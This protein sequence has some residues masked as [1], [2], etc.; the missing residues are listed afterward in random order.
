MA[1]KHTKGWST[2]LIS[3]QM[4]IKS[5][6]RYYRTQFRIVII[7]KFTSNTYWRGYGEKRT[8]LHCP[9]QCKLV[10]PLWRTRRFLKKL[11]TIY[12]NPTPGHM[13]G[14]NYNSKID[15]CCS[16]HSNTVYRSE[17]MEAT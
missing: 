6:M 7:N 11:T 16:V 15:I 14:E 3:I 12:S 13:Y 10:K 8:L 4:Q 17:D 5:T 1:Q 2:S 9:W